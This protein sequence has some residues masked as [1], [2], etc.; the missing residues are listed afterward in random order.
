MTY[1]VGAKLGITDLHYRPNRTSVHVGDPYRRQNSNSLVGFGRLTIGVKRHPVPIRR[2][3][4][5]RNT[6]AKDKSPGVPTLSR[7]NPHS[8]SGLEADAFSIWMPQVVCAVAV[9]GVG[10]LLLAA[11]INIDDAENLI[12]LAASGKQNLLAVRRPP[13]ILAPRKSPLP[14]AI[15][16]CQPNVLVAVKRDLGSIGRPTNIITSVGRLE[17]DDSAH[18]VAI[19]PGCTHLGFHRVVALAV[20]QTQRLRQVSSMVPSCTARTA[21]V[22]NSESS[23]CPG[24]RKSLQSH[25]DSLPKCTG[26]A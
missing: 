24:S 4:R 26:R 23:L 14:R 7:D 6:S 8:S 17:Y 12:V 5:L 22:G 13:R 2:P 9:A 21:H 11:A 20:A 25:P 15:S 10:N 3:G 19:H 1:R 16:V 18:S